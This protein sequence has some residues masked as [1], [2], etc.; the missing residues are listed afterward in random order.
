MMEQR[1]S[2]FL[3]R[4]RA[5]A[6]M[7]IH[8]WQ[9]GAW[10]AGGRLRRSTRQECVFQDWFGRRGDSSISTGPLEQIENQLSGWNRCRRKTVY[11]EYVF[12]CR[13]RESCRALEKSLTKQDSKESLSPEPSPLPQQEGPIIGGRESEALGSPLTCCVI[14]CNHLTL[15]EPQCLCYKIGII[16]AASQ[17]CCVMMV[18]PKCR[19]PR[20]LST[21]WFQLYNVLDKAKLWRQ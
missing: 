11:S 7:R 2:L 18:L 17:G 21:A 12:P 13:K 20:E 14:P 5:V 8:H 15:A 6:E 16:V 3:G 9:S 1:I 4:L 19:K 10:L